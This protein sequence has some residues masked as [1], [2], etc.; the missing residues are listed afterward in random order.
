MG[1][2]Q[3]LR[4]RKARKAFQGLVGPELLSKPRGGAGLPAGKIEAKHFQFVIILLD[5]AKPEEVPAI[6]GKVVSILLQHGAIL[7]SITSSLLVGLLGVPF[8]KGDSP[9]LRLRLVKALLAGNGD[10]LRIAHGQCTGAFGLLGT[11]GRWTYGEVIPEFSGILKKLLGSQFG[12][13]VEVS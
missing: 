4:R 8:P 7:S 10:R 5:D 1:I 6:I 3:M 9:E 2:F 11:E 13:A 12:T